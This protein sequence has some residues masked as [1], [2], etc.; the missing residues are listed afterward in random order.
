MRLLA[1]SLGLYKR[2]VLDH[3]LMTLITVCVIV[4]L[5]IAQARHFQLDASSDSLVLENDPDLRYYRLVRGRYGS[6]DYLIITYTST[7]DLFEGASLA[8]IKALRDD[9]SELER[10]ESVVSILDA[11]LFQ[12]PPVS[13]FA[14]GKDFKTLEMDTVDKGLAVR[15]FQESPLYTNLLLSED[16]KTTALQVNFAKDAAYQEL[17]QRQDGLR[18]KKSDEGL[19]AGESTELARI[20]KDV[21]KAN[22]RLLAREQRD[23]EAIRAV[24]AKHS[25]HAALF[26]GGIPMIIVDMIAYVKNDLMVFGAGVVVF[27]AITLTAIFRRPRWVIMPLGISL[28]AGFAMIGYVALIDWRVTVISSNFFS[29]MMIMTIAV[30]IHLVVR[31]REL[32]ADHPHAPQ[33]ELVAETVRSMAKP[34]FYTT[35]TTMVAFGSLIVS[36]IRPVIDFGLMMTIGVGIGFVLVFLIF[37]ASLMLLKKTRSTLHASRPPPLTHFSSELTVRHGGKILILA[38]LLMLVSL[39]GLFRL[40]VENRF[41]DYF[42]KSTEIYQGLAAIDQRLGGTTPLDVILDGYGKDYWNDPTLRDSV[43][44]IHEYL[45]QLPETGKVLSIATFMGVAEEVNDDI[46]LDNFYLN[47]IYKQMPDDIRARVFEPFAS[48][49]HDQIRFALRVRE[50]DPN[51]RRQALID[52]IHGYFVNEAAIPENQ[53]HISGMLVLYNNMLQSLFRSQILTLG[54]VFLA[55]M[56]MFFIAFRSIALA[57]IAIAPNVFPAVLVLGI[58]GWFGVSLDMMTITIAAIAVGISVHDTIHYIHRFREEFAKD[59]DYVAAVRRSHGT[60]GRAIYY[61]SLT[62]TVGFSI[63]ALSNFIPTIYFGLFTGFAMVVAVLAAL[64]VLPRLLILF[65]PLG[66]EAETDHGP[67]KSTSDAV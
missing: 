64:T 28:V 20:S 58:M 23:V 49:D 34:C 32:N 6:D 12:S 17:I 7:G 50:T 24:I 46:P 9:L 19:S 45:E 40:S 26:L 35:L 60:I 33:R 25:D 65:K 18:E 57:A 22:T 61:T 3:P 16:G 47:L 1:F 2:A 62:I 42:R 11:P 48:R 51:L 54:A 38:A 63:L 5:L 21:R 29:L 27:M 67:S 39:A 44:E 30:I 66:A 13:L 59:R 15:E 37:P 56:L 41:T 4:G 55:I 43:A 10:V 52:K 31:Y 36:G 14:M 8:R 53:L